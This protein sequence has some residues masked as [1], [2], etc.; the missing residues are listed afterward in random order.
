MKGTR[1]SFQ[2][3]NIGTVNIMTASISPSIKKHTALYSELDR[4]Y[5]KAYGQDRPYMD[6]SVNSQFNW[7][8][9]NSSPDGTEFWMREFLVIDLTQSLDNLKSN[10]RKSYKSLVNKQDGIIFSP[11]VLTG[12]CSAP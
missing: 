1:L 7:D 11:Y 6:F 3:E 9:L 10:L 2:I 5:S 8:A 12:L 4:K